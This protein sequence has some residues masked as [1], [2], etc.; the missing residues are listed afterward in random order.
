M[1]KNLCKCSPVVKEKIKDHYVC[2][3]SR[4]SARKYGYFLN[5]YFE[6]DSPFVNTQKYDVCYN[7]LHQLSF[8]KVYKKVPPKIEFVPPTTRGE[9]FI[10]RQEMYEQML[11]ECTKEES[12]D[13]KKRPITFEERVQES[14]KQFKKPFHKLNFRNRLQRIDMIASLII[15]SCIDRNKQTNFGPGYMKNNKEMANEITNVLNLIKDRIENKM[16][17][18]FNL[19]QYP[20]PIQLVEDD[21]QISETKTS[22]LLK[23]EKNTIWDLLEDPT[24]KLAYG[25][26]GESTGRGFERI[27]EKYNKLQPENPLPSTYHLNKKLPVQIVPFEHELITKSKSSNISTHVKEQILLGVLPNSDKIIK[28]EEDAIQMFCNVGSTDCTGE[29]ITDRSDNECTKIIGAKIDTSYIDTI[30]L[31]ARK[32][33]SK[34]LNIIDKIDDIIVINSFDGAEAFRTKNNVSSVVSFSS[35]LMTSRMIKHG[36]IKVGESFNICTWMQVMGKESYDLVDKV[37]GYQY[38]SNRHKLSI[39]ETSLKHAPQSKVWMY[40][41][42]DGKMLYS[43]LQHSMWNRKHHPF[44]L[45]KCH[46][47][48]GLDVS[49]GDTHQCQMIDNDEYIRLYER[50][51]RRLKHKDYDN[52]QHREWCDEKNAGVTHF[53]IDPAFLNISTLRFDIFHCTCAVTRTVMNFTRKFILRQSLDLRTEFTQCVLSKFWSPYHIYCWNN[54]CQFSSFKGNELKEFIS[55][56]NYISILIKEKI[57]ST[58]ESTNLMRTLDVLPSIFNFLRISSIDNDEEYV[59]KMNKFD[60]DVRLLFR[61]GKHTFLS[62]GN[63]TFYFHCL[64]FYLPCIAKVTFERHRVGLGL[65][66]M[67]GYERRNKESKNT[68]NRFCT[69]QHKSNSLL[70]NNVRRL[71]QVYLLECNAY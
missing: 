18:D 36:Q 19:M 44:L 68:I 22:E 25:I 5:R 2:H 16:S 63:V 45:C 43:L 11:K 61:Y 23:S 62:D 41:V 69:S 46:R 29:T 55:N 58:E 47:T 1:P 71:L 7:L 12:I 28:C 54:K 6:N 53:G 51:K 66:T 48:A 14:S 26:I 10:K 64:R 56:S 40:D 24:I 8:K 27:R 42:H 65:F 20:E 30:N 21:V 38:W 33:L 17:V 49:T 37:T 60:V 70:V 39:G 50:S 34:G 3:K 35:S 52:N 4:R 57:V 31:M 59:Q 32:H 15:G 13:I 67:Q 9:R